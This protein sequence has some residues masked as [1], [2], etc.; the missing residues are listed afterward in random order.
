MLPRHATGE[1]AL[2]VG[3]PIATRGIN[4]CLCTPLQPAHLPPREQSGRRLIDDGDISPPPASLLPVRAACPPPIDSVATSRVGERAPEF[5]DLGAEVLALRRGLRR[6]SFAARLHLG[7]CWRVPR[8]GSFAW[9]AR[10]PAHPNLDV[11][12]VYGPPPWRGVSELSRLL[13]CDHWGVVAG[14]VHGRLVALGAVPA[15]RFVLAGSVAVPVGR[16]ASF[17]AAV[18]SALTGRWTRKPGASPR[19]TRVRPHRAVRVDEA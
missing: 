18:A 17:E 6:G 8:V 3:A 15:V 11:P 9:R 2:G 16:S 1:H 13:G 5:A 4:K 14:L 12:R 7:A 10:P 19:F